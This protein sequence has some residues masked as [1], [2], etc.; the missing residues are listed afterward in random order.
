MLNGTSVIWR[1]GFAFLSVAF[2]FAREIKGTTGRGSHYLSNFINRERFRLRSEIRVLPLGFKFQ[3]PIL[4]A[5][6]STRF[7][8]FDSN[9][10]TIVCCF[11]LDLF[12][13]GTW[14]A[15]IIHSQLYNGIYNVLMSP[16]IGVLG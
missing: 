14:D 5:A 7:F 3:I 1:I 13:L 16:H 10:P 6:A 15:N 11:G 8:P 9:E 12:R 4:N 2:A